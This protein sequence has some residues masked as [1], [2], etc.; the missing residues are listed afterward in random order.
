MRAQ[1]EDT[2]AATEKV[3]VELLRRSKPE[4]RAEM[5]LSLSRTVMSLALSNLRRLHP[6][7]SQEELLA[8]FVEI[9]HGRDLAEALRQHIRRNR[10]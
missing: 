10:A 6:E 2:D 9:H 1:W 8:L 5:A 7:A 4:R 3:Y